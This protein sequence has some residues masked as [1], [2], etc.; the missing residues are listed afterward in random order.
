MQPSE[1]MKAHPTQKKHTP[2][3]VRTHCTSFSLTLLSPPP[4]PPP[5]LP[6]SRY[7]FSWVCALPR[8]R[9]TDQFSVRTP[10]FIYFIL[11]GLAHLLQLHPYSSHM[12]MHTVCPSPSLQSA[13]LPVSISSPASPC[14]D[15]FQCVVASRV[16]VRLWPCPAKYRLYREVSWII[17]SLYCNYKVLEIAQRER[18][19]HRHLVHLAELVPSLALLLQTLLSWSHL[20]LKFQRLCWPRCCHRKWF[21]QLH[22]DHP[23]ILQSGRHHI[24]LDGGRI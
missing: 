5:L 14:S 1:L 20:S 4:H 11:P 18:A 10:F 17:W 15:L 12:A 6:I 23:L 22:T 3:S 13:S 8:F 24:T 2:I 19:A 7:V 9:I 16:C 21:C